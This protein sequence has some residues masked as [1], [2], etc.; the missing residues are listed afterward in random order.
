MTRHQHFDYVVVGGGSAGCAAAGGLATRSGGSVLLI[1]AGRDARTI[2]TRIP[3]FVRKAIQQ[4]DWG[5]VSEPDHSREGRREGWVRGRVL[6]GSSSVNGMMFVRGAPGDYDRWAAMQNPGWNWADVEPHFRAIETSDQP[7]QSRGHDGPLHV[8]TVR[9][10]HALTRA[11]LDAAAAAGYP[12]NAD[13]NAGDQ[14]GFGLAQLSQRR[15][16]R[17]SSADAFLRSARK[18][19][20]FTLWDDCDAQ[21]L[22][23]R[24]GVATHL[25]CTRKGEE[26][27]VSADRFILTAG[28]V[29]TP[30]LLML[31]GVGDPEMLDALGI[32]CAIAS[33]QVGRNMI[34]HP[35][36]RLVYETSVPSRSP[37]GGIM[38][39]IGELTDFV[40]HREGL[41]AGAFEAAGFVRSDE[42]LSAPDI[43]YH[44]LP[45][46]V[47]DPVIH[48]DPVLKR[49]SLTIYANLSHPSGRGALSLASKDP[50]APPKIL[51][52]LLG[53]GEQDIKAL[54]AGLRIARQIMSSE[55]MRSLVVRERT[56]GPALESDADLES[57]V[58]RNTEIAYHIA[59]TCRMGSDPDAV[60]TPDLKLRGVENIWV[61]DASIFPDLI[62]GNTNAACMMIGTKLASQLAGAASR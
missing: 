20:N 47:E 34:E 10:P 13:Y 38:R 51:P 4:F 3:G 23:L 55:P 46:G 5:Y 29:G 44:F 50:A 11:F 45:L 39:S 27:V 7:G 48:A 15:G 40:R 2:A 28:A 53:G 32:P 24:D 42:R 61:A 12:A 14:S 17:H 56:P 35:L 62:S 19:D 1:E 49:P 8:R 41:L 25:I 59:G 58:R 36:V 30:K 60:V 57:Y 54:A 22:I 43:Q 21:R 9:R 31:S 37:G 26:V 33:L 16:L 18:R 6:G 52:N